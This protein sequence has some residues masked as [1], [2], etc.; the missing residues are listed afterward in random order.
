[1]PKVSVITAVYNVE[2][3]LRRSM[4]CLMN[5][6]L[7][8]M[9]FICIDDCSTDNSLAILREYAQKDSRFKIIASEKNSGAAVARNKGLDIATGEY[10]G[11]ID[12]DDAIDLNY[13]EE[14]YK[15]AKEG[16]YDIAKCQEKIISIKGKESI[17]TVQDRIR[18]EGLHSFLN[19]WTTAI[20]RASMIF[21]NKIRFDDEI[22]KAQDTLFL[23]QIVLIAKT[24]TLVD[25]IYYY[26]FRREDSLHSA[27][28]TDKKY[29]SGIN[30]MHKLLD[31]INHSNICEKDYI[32]MYYRLYNCYFEYYYKTNNQELKQLLAETAI[33]DWKNCKYQKSLMNALPYKKAI[34]IIKKG[35]NNDII[36]FMGQFKS[37]KELKKHSDKN[38]FSENIFSV[39]KDNRNHKVL[40]MF[41][42]KLKFKVKG[43]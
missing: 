36:K 7:K 6:T 38:S 26:Y 1:M 8:D 34:N 4:D 12:S 43:E 3:Y 19:E 32:N 35:N 18:K 17:G 11:F 41:G 9:E 42:I 29:I 37:I 40:T 28:L 16:N 10:I 20:Y 39:K 22:I 23:G 21:D 31:I 24:I 13:Y 14:L 5:Q 2:P 15:K 25:G 27:V 30:A 33:S